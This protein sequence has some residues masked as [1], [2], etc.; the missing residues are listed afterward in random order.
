MRFQIITAVLLKEIFVECQAT[1]YVQ[2]TYDS[3]GR[4]S[5]LGPVD[6]KVKPLGFFESL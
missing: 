1:S 2:V 6:P 4:G 3:K 5:P